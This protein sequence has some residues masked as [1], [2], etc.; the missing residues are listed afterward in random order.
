MS[1]AVR[2]IYLDE[3]GVLVTAERVQAGSL[4][5][6]LGR[7]RRVRLATGRP[8][9]ASGGALVAIGALL[10]LRGFGLLRLVGAAAAAVGVLRARVEE[11]SILLSI[12]GPTGEIEG[13]LLATPDRAWAE[14]V[15]QSI[16][17]AVG[18]RDPNR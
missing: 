13:R 6:A 5:V 14:V 15:R 1:G 2:L 10:F 4:D 7:V 11:H 12:D 8:G 18:H 9:L 16:E 3:R 17:R